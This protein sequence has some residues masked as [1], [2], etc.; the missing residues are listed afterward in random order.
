[1]TPPRCDEADL[2]YVVTDANT[3]ALRLMPVPPGTLVVVL[4]APLE[5]ELFLRN[6]DGSEQRIWP[7]EE[8]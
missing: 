2:R 5:V 4:D 1:M 7:A 6:A 3:G 8:A